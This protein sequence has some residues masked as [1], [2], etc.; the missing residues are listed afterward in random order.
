MRIFQ[1]SHNRL[2]GCILNGIDRRDLQRMGYG[3]Y[4]GNQGSHYYQN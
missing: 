4:Y 1:T 2:T 3:S